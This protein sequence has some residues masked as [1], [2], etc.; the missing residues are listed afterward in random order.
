MPQT[1]SQYN[2]ERAFAINFQE[3]RLKK[4]AQLISSL[5]AGAMLDIGCSTGTWALYWKNLGWTVTGV[6][7]NPSAVDAAVKNGV[8]ARCCDLN[9]APLPFSDATFDL[10]F[11]GEVIEHIVDT[12]FF[13]K[14]LTR[15]VKPG[16]HV[17]LTTPNLASLENRLRLLLGKYPR[18]LDYRLTDCG[19]VRGYTLG[20]LKNQLDAQGLRV[21][22]CLGNWVPFLPQSWMDDVRFPWLAPTGTWLPG[23]SMDLI[24]LAQKQPA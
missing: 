22:R 23:L 7:V 3:S 14:E 16:G 12:D 4:A 6:D 1:V 5:R 17:L 2:A 15:C 13:L 10:I 9:A 19:H 21:R 20:A 8:T 18:W 24:V 11:A